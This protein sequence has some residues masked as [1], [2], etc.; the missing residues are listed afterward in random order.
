MHELIQKARELRGLLLRDPHRPTYHVSMSS[1][2]ATRTGVKA[3][4]SPDGA[5]EAWDMAAANQW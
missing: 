4:R 3:C 1:A 5:V 2:A